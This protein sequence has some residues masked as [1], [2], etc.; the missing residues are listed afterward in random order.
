MLFMLNVC[1]MVRMRVHLWCIAGFGGPSSSFISHMAAMAKG[2][3]EALVTLRLRWAWSRL[4]DK[5]QHEMLQ[6]TKWWGQLWPY[7]VPVEGFPWALPHVKN[8]LML[9]QFTALA[10]SRPS[11]PMGNKADVGMPVTRALFH[12]VDTL[13]S[14]CCCYGGNMSNVVHI[15]E[16][17]ASIN[18]L[19]Q[20]RLVLRY[21]PN[22]VGISN[23]LARQGW[24]VA[25]S[26]FASILP[27]WAS[28]WFGVPF[29]LTFASVRS[30]CT[31]DII[32]YTLC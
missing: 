31:S 5:K 23:F 19:L 14:C 13:F 18:R 26:A 17:A 11:V 1:I 21:K 7:P 4:R 32:V 3:D 25:G 9:E 12:L 24:T 16:V 8:M 20:K 15:Q 29:L 10:P 27:A 22:S 28:C 6:G 2:I 30:L